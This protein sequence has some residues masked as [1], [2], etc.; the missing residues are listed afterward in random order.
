MLLY[1][2]TIP[3]YVPSIL[4]QGRI[5]VERDAQAQ[6]FGRPAVWLSSN[7]VMENT[8]LK[9]IRYRG[10]FITLTFKEQAKKVGVVRFVFVYPTVRLFVMDWPTYRKYSGIH[11]AN[12]DGLEKAGRKCGANP[13][14]WYASVLPVYRNQWL[15][16][17]AVDP[18]TL[19]WSEM[20]YFATVP[21]AKC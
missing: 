3:Q 16:V 8:A 5:N 11:T 19:Q 21:G 17:E 20:A 14:E 13:S 4:A 12:A 18:D 15:R 2:Y 10:E 7:P 6:G 1:H 9:M